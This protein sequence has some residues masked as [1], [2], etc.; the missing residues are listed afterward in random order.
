MTL[1]WPGVGRAAE[2]STITDSKGRFVF[3]QL[4]A[5]DYRIR[6]TKSGYTFD[7]L[8]QW[9]PA[10]NGIIGGTAIALREGDWIDN[11]D[12][13]L[14]P[15]GAISGRVVD[16]RGEPVVGVLVRV[17]AQ[18]PIAGTFQ[19]VAGPVGMTDDRGVYRIAGLPTRTIP[20]DCAFSAIGSTRVDAGD[21]AGGNDTGRVSPSRR[22]SE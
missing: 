18:F 5:S 8:G 1:Q 6:T 7:T 15:P 4:A 19:L 21:D 3:Q 17:L 20:R 12:I 22:S 14:W 11:I 16:E 9:F 10:G 13:A 2:K